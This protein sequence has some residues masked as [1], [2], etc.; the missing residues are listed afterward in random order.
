MMGGAR[1]T[2]RIRPSHERSACRWSGLTSDQRI[3]P[4]AS[5]RHRYRRRRH[6]YRCL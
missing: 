2:T 6:R 5:R 1:D 4:A 3:G